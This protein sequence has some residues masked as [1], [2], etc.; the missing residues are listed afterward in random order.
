LSPDFFFGLKKKTPPPPAHSLVRE[1][2]YQ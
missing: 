1:H 2:S